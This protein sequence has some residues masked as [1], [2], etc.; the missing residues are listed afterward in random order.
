MI[1]QEAYSKI[2]ALF[3]IDTYL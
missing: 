3:Q 2:R 1:Y